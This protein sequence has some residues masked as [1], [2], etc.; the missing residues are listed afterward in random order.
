MVA[1]P[2]GSS[3][4]ASDRRPDSQQLVRQWALLRLL[5]ESPR[6]WSVKELSEQLQVSKAT[7]DRDLATLERDFALVEESVG[8]Q[9]KV[10]RIDTKIRA[11]ETLTFGVTELLALY[12]AQ[13]SLGALAGTP[14]HDDLSS[15]ATKISFRFSIPNFVRST[16]R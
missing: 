6:A 14:V 10:Y 1:M 8:K 9:K 5:S 13:Q 3:S 7:V 15:V 11:L 2:P 16:G 4:K 12:A